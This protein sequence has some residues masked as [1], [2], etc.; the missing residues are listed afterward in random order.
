MKQLTAREK[1]LATIVGGAF[2][3]LLNLV[4]ITQFIKRQAAARI[5]LASKTQEWE[6]TQILFSERDLWSKRDAWLQAKQ[7]KLTNEG[8]AG[9]QLLDSIK[10]VAKKTDVV[11]ENP[12]IGSPIKT[13][14]YRSVPVNIET[15]SSWSA[16]IA[17]LQAMQQPEEF[18][19][20]ESANIAIDAADASMMRG[21]FKIARWYAP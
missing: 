2:F 6:S 11:L 16:L 13:T 15:K 19:V 12:S 5:E 1:L 14:L 18:I 9:V 17:F 4:L 8:S 3:A 10:K 20:F 21:K 7:P